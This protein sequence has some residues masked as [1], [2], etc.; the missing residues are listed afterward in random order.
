MLAYGYETQEEDDYLVELAE[1]AT[2]HFALLSSPGAFLVDVFP[3]CTSN[4]KLP[5][6][7]PVTL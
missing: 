6:P 2:E 5:C 4:V 1:K 7:L 3:I